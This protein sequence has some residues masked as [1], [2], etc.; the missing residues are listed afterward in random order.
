MSG[1][2]L[3]EQVSSQCCIDA[4]SSDTSCCVFLED[5]RDCCDLDLNHFDWFEEGGDV[6]VHTWACLVL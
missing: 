6:G 5:A 1:P 2:L 3:V 4:H